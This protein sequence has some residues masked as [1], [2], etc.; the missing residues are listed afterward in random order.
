MR[1]RG[2]GFQ[3]FYLSEDVRA[4]LDPEVVDTTL[5]AARGFKDQLAFEVDVVGAGRR[6]PGVPLVAS[7]KQKAGPWSREVSFNSHSPFHPS[8]P[9]KKQRF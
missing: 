4:G 6:I 7:G 5:K 3:H 8:L 2:V 1:S 9:D